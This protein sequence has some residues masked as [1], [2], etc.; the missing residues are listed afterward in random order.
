M[1]VVELFVLAVITEALTEY[2]KLLLGEEIAK[3]LGKWVMLISMAIGIGIAF[4]LNV[5]LFIIIGL[6]VQ[7]PFVGI[8]L[9]GIF[10]SR[11]SNYL[12]DILKKLDG[13]KGEAKELLAQT[14]FNNDL[15]VEVG[16]Y[17]ANG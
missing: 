3:K 14:S 11:G 10:G 9:S 12:H 6:N 1:K 17:N 8:I 7:I 2:V 5:D 15:S 13:A 16:A 4:T